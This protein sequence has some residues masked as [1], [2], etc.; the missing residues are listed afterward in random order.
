MKNIW[1]LN[2]P[3]AKQKQIDK[4]N[5]LS[6]KRFRRGLSLSDARVP[7]GA[8]SVYYRRGKIGIK[9]LRTDFR[10]FGTGGYKSM[11]SLKRSFMWR[12]A[13]KE[14]NLMKKAEDSGLV[15][16]PY[17]V[18]PVRLGKR[19]YPAIFMEHIQGTRFDFF[20]DGFN[21]KEFCEAEKVLKAKE[22][23]LTRYGVDH[24]LDSG[25]GN[26]IVVESIGRK[27]IKVKLIDFSPGVCQEV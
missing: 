17:C 12:E 9:V 16:I 20:C 13:L 7:S 23:A 21:R 19:F 15:P 14:Y 6:I 26:A 11:R 24:V 18:K 5:Y 27:I 1:N 4:T 25:G 3:R 8:Y 2:T 22:M 10:Y